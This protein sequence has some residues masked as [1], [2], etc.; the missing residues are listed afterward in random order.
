MTRDEWDALV[1]KINLAWPGSALSDNQSN[2]YF[3]V[4]RDT[5]PAEISAVIVELVRAG[6]TDPPPP[7]RL[8]RLVAERSSAADT[9]L[10]ITLQA[11]P[12]SR[13]P[14]APVGKPVPAGSPRASAVTATTQAPVP[15]SPTRDG[16]W[17]THRMAIIGISILALCVGVGAGVGIAMAV[18]PDADA[19][20]VQGK[21]EGY[22]SGYDEGKS[23]GYDNGY[24]VGYDAGKTGVFTSLSGDSPIDGRH[25]IVQYDDEDGISYWWSSPLIEGSCY[26]INGSILT[27]SI[28]C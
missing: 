21:S 18:A 26:R 20:Y 25:Y 1:K 14:A 17:S 23:E 8:L 6:A 28:L 27:R 5:D 15:P 19:A 3:T 4:L 24:D 12:A 11:A 7:N 10:G 13:A 9:A 16:L 22:D 2:V